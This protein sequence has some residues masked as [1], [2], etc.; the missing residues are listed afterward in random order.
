MSSL[1]TPTVD[2]IPVRG[3]ELKAPLS[4]PCIPRRKKE[5][6]WNRPRQAQSFGQ[7]KHTPLPAA[8]FLSVSDL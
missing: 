8:S 5:H 4:G 2:C 7:L 1:G 3:S 6:V